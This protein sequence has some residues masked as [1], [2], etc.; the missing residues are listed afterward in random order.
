MWFTRYLAS[1]PTQ[2]VAGKILVQ[3]R[4]RNKRFSVRAYA[5]ISKTSREITGR[6]RRRLAKRVSRQKG[7]R[8]GKTI[9]R[10]SEIEQRNGQYLNSRRLGPLYRDNI[11]ISLTL[12]S[13]V[14]SARLC[15]PCCAARPQQG[16]RLLEKGLDCAFE[17]L[18]PA[19]CVWLLLVAIFRGTY[20]PHETS[21]RL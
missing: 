5:S 9:R 10:V 19:R 15:V 12:F 20:S 7:V 16:K 2:G 14:D 18:L 4:E 21:L 3:R 11:C 8:G 1:S 6:E 13:A 17:T